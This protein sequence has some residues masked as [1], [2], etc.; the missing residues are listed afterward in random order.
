MASKQTQ[1]K[2][3][4]ELH[5]AIGR[6]DVEETVRLLRDG[7]D[8]N[9]IG[10]SSR[11][12]KYAFTALCTAIKAAD[13]AIRQPKVIATL[14]EACPG[15]RFVETDFEALRA[16]CIEIIRRLI[17]TGADPNRPSYSRTPLSLAAGHCGDVEI[18]RLL[19][20]AGANP[21]GEGWSPFSKLPR[22]KGGLAYYGNAIHEAT[23]KG[24]T[25]VVQLLC[26]RGADPLA[27]NHEG[28]TALQ[29]ARER[30][31]ADIVPFL[32]QYE[33]SNVAD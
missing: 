15:A 26:S 25:E 31:L 14:R 13:Y 24:F 29:I 17:A 12:F 18:T 4:L 30:G 6:G 27:R 20:D 8:P 3:E 33:Q 5:R 10:E 22:P 32:E 1:R 16:N 2:R 28:K 9:C 23:E 21:A 7:V 19:L 11:N